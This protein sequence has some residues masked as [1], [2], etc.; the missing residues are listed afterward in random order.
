MSFFNIPSIGTF[1]EDCGFIKLDKCSDGFHEVGK[2]GVKSITATGD[3]KV[4]FISYED[5]TIAYV[6]SSMGYPHIIP[7]TRLN[8]KSP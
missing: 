1:D 4:E 8:S 6:T 7:S 3:K 5:K 2:N